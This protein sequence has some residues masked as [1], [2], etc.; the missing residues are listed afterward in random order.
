MQVSKAEHFEATGAKSSL[1]FCTRTSRSPALLHPGA[2]Y[3]NTATATM[4]P[5]HSTSSSQPLASEGACTC[6]G[7]STSARIYRLL[8]APASLDPE[9]AF[10]TP[11]IP[12][13]PLLAIVCDCTDEFPVA[14]EADSPRIAFLPYQDDIVGADIA[15]KSSAFFIGPLRS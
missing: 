15:M 9:Y 5:R 12:S 4:K 7:P 11:P 1:R 6:N 2:A 8:G 10:V 14:K 3:N 13:V